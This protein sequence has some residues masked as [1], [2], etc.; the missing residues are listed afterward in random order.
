[1]QVALPPIKQPADLISAH[2]AVAAAIA[3]Q[4][5]TPQEAAGLSAVLETH[6]R[7]FELV[8]QEKRVEELEAR[9][10]GLKAKLT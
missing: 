3:E 5:I 4:A 1:V 8:G 7:A 10:R 6:R 9:V 2:A